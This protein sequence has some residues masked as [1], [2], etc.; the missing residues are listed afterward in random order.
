M[1][2][3]KS[4]MSKVTVYSPSTRVSTGL[5]TT[6]KVDKSPSVESVATTPESV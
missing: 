6:T 3:L 1:F 2:P 4:E 5:S